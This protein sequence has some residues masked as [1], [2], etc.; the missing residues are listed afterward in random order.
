MPNESL[1]KNRT[2]IKSTNEDITGKMPANEKVADKKSINIRLILGRLL[3]F[4][5]IP[6][7]LILF[8]KIGD[9]RYYLCSLALIILSMVPFFLSFEK[10]KPQARE[11]VTL[12]VL[13]A[14]AVASRTAFIMIPHFKPMTAIV[15]IAGMAFGPDAG[16]LTGA[17]S[18]FVSNFIFGQGPWTPWQMFAYG[19]A[20]FLGGIFCSRKIIG[21]EKRIATPIFGGITVIAI[22]GP[23]LDLCSIFTMANEVTMEW[24]GAIFL[25]G[26][27]VNAIHAAATVLTLIVLCKP[28]MEKLDRIKVKYGMMR[29]DE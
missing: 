14:I 17:M 23:I 9:R 21:S 25:S 15:I 28:M 1:D 10:R 24:V 8:W 26:L 12:A 19:V 5:G 18:G 7:V 6:A 3:M 16:F 22:V 2:D 13:C 20:G 29:E 4:I 11:L 27:P